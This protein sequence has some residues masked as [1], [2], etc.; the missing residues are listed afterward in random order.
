[1]TKERPGTDRVTS[2]PKRGLEIKLHP[3]AQTD[4]LTHG[5]GNSMTKLAQWGRIC[6]I[7]QLV[8]NR[9]GV[10]GAVLQTPS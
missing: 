4:S 5:H 8:F 3:M 6:E 1:M 9:P 10:D 7:L 2:G